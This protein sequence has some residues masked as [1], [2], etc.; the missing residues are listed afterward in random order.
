MIHVCGECKYLSC[1]GSVSFAPFFECM[2][3]LN[4]APSP[5]SLIKVRL[6]VFGVR[7]LWWSSMIIIALL[8]LTAGM[9][10]LTLSLLSVSKVLVV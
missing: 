9:M 3:K 6:I 8:F 5:S 4:G 7:W 10:Y 1:I 2:G